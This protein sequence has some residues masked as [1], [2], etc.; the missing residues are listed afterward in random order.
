MKSLLSLRPTSCID[1][2]VTF[3]VIEWLN[4]SRKEETMIFIDGSIAHRVCKDYEDDH[5]ELQPMMDMIRKHDQLIF[6]CMLARNNYFILTHNK[7]RKKSKIMLNLIDNQN[8]DIK[9]MKSW[10]R[11]IL[12]ILYKSMIQNLTLKQCSKTAQ[13]L[14]IEKNLD[15]IKVLLSDWR[16][17]DTTVR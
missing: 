2:G 6:V 11:P 1:Y 17:T 5:P 10:S 15:G 12:Y 3:L 9:R 8:T 7:A 16:S 13:F 4:R 14:Q